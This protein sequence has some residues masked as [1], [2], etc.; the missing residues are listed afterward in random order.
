VITISF[1]QRL[2]GL[3]LSRKWSQSNLSDKINVHQTMITQYE[4]DQK[5]PSTETLIEIAKIF[6]VSL[7]YL[8]GL[9]KNKMRFDVQELKEDP[10]LYRLVNLMRPTIKG[11]KVSDAE[12]EMI[13]LFLKTVVK[14][15][16]EQGKLPKSDI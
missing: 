4:N 13:T 3:R 5:F 8:V 16:E 7:D 14:Q 10:D 15:L 9:S 6:D 12:W 11:V 1:G 2:K